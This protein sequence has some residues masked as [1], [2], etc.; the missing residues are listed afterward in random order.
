MP[1]IVTVN[2]TQSAAPA[3]STLQQKGAFISQGRTTLSANG[4]KFLT[5]LSDLTS[6]LASSLSISTITWTSGTVTVKTSTS[7]PASLPSGAK[8]PTTIAGVT[9]AAYNGQYEATVTGTD[10]FTY[11]LAA[12]PGTETVLGTCTITD[13]LTAMATTFFA[14]GSQQGVYVLELGDGTYANGVSDLET[15]ITNNP[16]EFYSYLVPR[17]WDGESTFYTFLANY[18]ALNAKVYFWV[19]TTLSTYTNYTSTMK[20]VVT[21][22][23]AP[24]T[25]LTEFSLAAPFWVSLHYRPSTTNKVTPFAFSFLY[26]V[27]A[28]PT[29]GNSSTL[30][31]LKNANVNYVGTGAEGGLT[32]TM[33]FWGTTQDG[34]DFTYWYSVDWI[35]INIDLDISNAVMNGSNN[36]LNPLDY[37]QD[38][39]NRLQDVA[40]NTV[41]SA[42]TYGLAIGT[43]TKTGLSG[44]QFTSELDAGTFAAQDVVNAVPFL[45]Y[46][47]DNP[48][49]YPLGIY[50]GLSV[51]YIPARGFVSIVFNVNVT[52]F[53]TQ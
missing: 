48:S 12:D 36:Q 22:V 50:N 34:R 15:Y 8:F 26:G 37:N 7:L 33:L 39:I 44:T 2:V 35:Q 47:T 20:D 6:I 17:A 1:N 16:G 42:I 32:N 19:T 18:E 21:L 5:Q 46:T 43:V 38:G 28:Y 27:T 23:E 10:T 29:V 25:P 11:S 4:S 13:E 53:L 14:Q 41:A 31:S 45:T 30:T 9:P 3:P 40:G 24:S 49:D 51:V 52:D